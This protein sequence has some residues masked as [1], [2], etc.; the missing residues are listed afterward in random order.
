MCTSVKAVRDVSLA[1]RRADWRCSELLHGCLK[2]V[3]IAA[4]VCHCGLTL[5]QGLRP[6]QV[7]G[8]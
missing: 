8:E 7:G 1:L 5:M 4:R 3:Y 6:S 2:A